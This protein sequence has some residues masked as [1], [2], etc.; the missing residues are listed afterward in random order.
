MCEPVC[1]LAVVRQEQR[2][3]RVG[4]EPPDGYDAR[5]MPHEADDGRPP[6][7]VADGGDDAGRL[8]QQHIREPLLLQRLAV[9]ANIVVGADEGV[10]LPRLP[11]DRNAPGLDQR[12]GPPP[13][14]NPSASQPGVQPHAG[15]LRAATQT[16]A[17]RA[18]TRAW[19]EP[20]PLRRRGL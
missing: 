10:Q 19:H 9:E 4:I 7:R 14:S 1:K 18:M 12:V 11:V 15:S 6:M 5:G 13:R 2:A 3:G 16:M 20:C 17:A 8:V